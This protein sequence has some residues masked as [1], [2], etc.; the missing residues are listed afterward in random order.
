[1][2][3]DPAETPETIPPLLTVA[4]DSSP[5]DHGVVPEGVPLPVNVIVEPTQTLVFPE[6][7]GSAFTVIV[8]VVVFAVP[9]LPLVTAQ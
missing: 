9:Q 2:N 7:V 1:M 4:I 6:I 3:T 5:E 8:L